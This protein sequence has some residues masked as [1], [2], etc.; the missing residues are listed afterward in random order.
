MARI[1]ILMMPDHVRQGWKVCCLG[2]M[3]SQDQV[4]TY[5]MKKCHAEG[6]CSN[7]SRVNDGRN[8]YNGNR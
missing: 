4:L 6:L 1:I 2:L 3:L 5:E 8:A 7:E